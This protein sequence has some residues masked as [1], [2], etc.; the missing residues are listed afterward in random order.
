MATIPIMG[1]M[2]QSDSIRQLPKI[3]SRSPWS[4]SLRTTRR[5]SSDL[6][7]KS[8]PRLAKSR[9]V[10][11]DWNVRAIDVI[12]VTPI[13]VW[14]SCTLSSGKTGIGRLPDVWFWS[15]SSF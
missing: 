8:R 9:V 13:R 6:E 5:T 4:Q 2:V 12:S 11:S 3:H 1:L 15:I 10:N 7:E 14:S